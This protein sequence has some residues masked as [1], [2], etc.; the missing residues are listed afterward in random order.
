MFASKLRGK[1]SCPTPPTLRRKV[2]LRKIQIMLSVLIDQPYDRVY[3]VDKA[4]NLVQTEDYDFVNLDNEWDEEE[5]GE[6]L[7]GMIGRE[8]TRG[9]ADNEDSEEDE[10]KDNRNLIDDNTA[11][12]LTPEQ[13]LALKTQGELHL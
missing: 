7:S 2:K 3:D 4:G 9:F 1:K 5:P 6:I 12:K 8:L 10:E 13:I 11:Q